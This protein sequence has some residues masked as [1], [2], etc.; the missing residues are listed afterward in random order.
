MVSV[1]VE[2]VDK[3]EGD[4]EEEGCIERRKT[5]R[6]GKMREIKGERERL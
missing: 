5:S 1:A 3:W 4:T 2:W 6:R